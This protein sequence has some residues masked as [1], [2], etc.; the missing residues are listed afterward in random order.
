MPYNQEAFEPDPEQLEEKILFELG[1]D[2][3]YIKMEP[4]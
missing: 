2:E 1:L 3:I 4:I